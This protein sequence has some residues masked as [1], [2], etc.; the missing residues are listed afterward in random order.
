M[1]TKSRGRR[2]RAR[3]VDMRVN[4]VFVNSRQIDN[5]FAIPD[6]RPVDRRSVTDRVFRRRCRDAYLY[7]FF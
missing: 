5:A 2:I 7:P 1:P 4:R 3:R 6:R